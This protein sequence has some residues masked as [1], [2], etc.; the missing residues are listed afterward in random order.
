MDAVASDLS[1]SAQRDRAIDSLIADGLIEASDG[2][3]RLP[4]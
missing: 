1:D 2:I 3:L 4:R